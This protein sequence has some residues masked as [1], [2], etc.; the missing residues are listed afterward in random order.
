MY[1]NQNSVKPTH[2]PVLLQEILS[3]FP[4][5]WQ[6]KS[7][8]DCTFGRGGHCSAVLNKFSQLEVLALDRDQEAVNHSQTLKQ[9]FPNRLECLNLNFHNFCEQYPTK[10]FDAVLMDLG[11][12]SPQLDQAS[13]GFSFDQDGPLDMRMDQNQTLTAATIVNSFSK[14][15][16]ENL[17]REYGEIRNPYK[18][19]DSI[20][21]Q[22]QNNKFT[23]TRQL[24]KVIL[25]HSPKRWFRHPATLY[26]MALRMFVNQE[27]VGLEDSLPKFLNNLKQGAYFIILTFHSLEDRIVKKAFKKFVIDNQGTLLNKKVI[28]A[29]TPE[30]KKNPRSRSA[31]L[32][33]FIK[34]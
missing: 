16:L 19:V 33:I 13:R 28:M 26:F 8:L 31:K 10:N 30:R 25:Q 9:Q 21:N 34:S 11:V 29:K 24:V 27:L 4:E 20:F 2:Q 17:F 12:S 3:A 7:F 6:G 14:K 1:N 5:G 15:D 32:R 18:I 23:T 22:R